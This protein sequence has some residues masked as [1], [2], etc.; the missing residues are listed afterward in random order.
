M[1][2]VTVTQRAGG[3]GLAVPGTRE[4]R[5]VHGPGRFDPGILR[6]LFLLLR[7]GFVTT[8]AT[9]LLA[10]AGV[11]LVVAGFL[12]CDAGCVDVTRTGRLHSVFSMPGAIGLPLAAMVSGLVFRRDGRFGTAWQ[13]LSFWLGLVSLGSG[14]IIAAELTEG[15]TGCCSAPRCGRALPG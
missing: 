6:R 3:G 7:K 2:K 4:R 5:R 12:P 10:I 1:A 8:L 15:S 14:P 11:S 9:G 13:V